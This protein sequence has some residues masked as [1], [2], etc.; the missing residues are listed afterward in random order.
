MILDQTRHYIGAAILIAVSCLAVYFF[1][2]APMFK[3]QEQMAVLHGNDVKTPLSTQP[4]NAQAAA[5]G[6][7]AD[8]L[9]EKA[10]TDA[11]S[12]RISDLSAAQSTVASTIASSTGLNSQMSAALAEGLTRG[13]PKQQVIRVETAPLAPTSAATP[14]PS[15]SNI[16]ADMLA[17]LND[18]QTK[19]HVDSTIKISYEDKPFSPVFA[20]YSSSGSG[21]G[22]TLRHTKAL[23]L[24]ALA[25]KTRANGIEPGVGVEHVIKGTSAGLGLFAGYDLKAHAP[26]AGLFISVH[27]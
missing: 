4:A 23:D 27:L 2:L 11:L 22:Y 16:K 5:L 7:V 18:P 14:G 8:A 9:K 19:V 25:L 6:R 13:A 21:I 3:H 15:D 10:L 26:Q 12:G 24:D 17:V 1:I 20:A